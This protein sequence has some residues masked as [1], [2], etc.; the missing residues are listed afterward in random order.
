[1][2]VDEQLLEAGEGDVGELEFHFRGGDGCLA[3]FGDVLFSRA[4]RLHHLINGAVG[5]F[6]ELFA[7]AEGE[8]VDDLGLF[9]GEEALVVAA[10]WEKA[11]GVF[12]GHG[13]W[14]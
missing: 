11:A 3:A 8:I 7:E 5:A 1:M 9:I 2:I 14:R 10:L 13:W 4:R 12:G 6:E